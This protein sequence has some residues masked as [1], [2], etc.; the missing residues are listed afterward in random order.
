MAE[1][2]ILE[3]GT[4]EVLRNFAAISSG[5]AID[6]GNVLRVIH[7]RKHLIARV[8]IPQA[9]TMSFAIWNLGRFLAALEMF[10]KPKLISDGNGN[11]RRR[12]H[13]WRAGAALSPD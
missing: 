9:I 3:K 8:R 13:R 5:I 7:P 10:P 4:V 12:E 2:L 6:P 1:E 11:S